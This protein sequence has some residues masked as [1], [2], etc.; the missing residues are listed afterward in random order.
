V[1]S[2]ELL[3]MPNARLIF[4]IDETRIEQIPG[5]AAV[6]PEV[7]DLVD[8]DQGFTGTNGEPMGLV[9]CMNPDGSVRWGASVYD[10]ELELLQK[11]VG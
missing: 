2:W 8:L 4:E 11:S 3:K 6:K 1:D 9:Y 10:W 5:R 7:G